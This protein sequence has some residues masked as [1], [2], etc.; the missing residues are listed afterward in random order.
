MSMI[1]QGMLKVEVIP[2]EEIQEWL[3]CAQTEL[4]AAIDSI[5]A[6]METLPAVDF[7]PGL[8]TEEVEGTDEGDEYERSEDAEGQSDQSEYAAAPATQRQTDY[9]VEPEEQPQYSP[10]EPERKMVE[11]REEQPE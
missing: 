4:P 2:P 9:A 10:P 3:E 11:Y 6:V 8:E 1:S 5:T 7:A